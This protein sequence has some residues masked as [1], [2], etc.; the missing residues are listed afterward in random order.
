ME[1]IIS[2]SLNS[3]VDYKSYRKLI[4]SLLEIGKSTGVSQSEDLLHFSIMND[5]RMQ[6]LDKTITLNESIVAA[7]ANLSGTYTLLTLTE[8]WCGDAAHALPVLD[9]IATS[10][11]N[12]KLKIVLRDENE[13]L[14][15]QF[16][17]DGSK[18]IP[19][20]IVLNELKEVVGTWGP[21]PSTATDM[22]NDYKSEHGALDA[23][24]KKELQLWYNKD[25]GKTM[26]QD[27][28][29][30]FMTFENT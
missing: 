9:K 5:R 3:A 6:R 28:E 18:S 21:R 10:T 1:E 23:D 16:L 20:V 13:E 24:F 2:K 12:L 25:K 19:K 27:L 8:G 14:M 29:E 4:K 26:Q 17:T 11:D 7:A 30:L 22:V 15:S